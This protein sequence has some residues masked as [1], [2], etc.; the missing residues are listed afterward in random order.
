MTFVSMTPRQFRTYIRRHYPE[1]EVTE[2]RRINLGRRYTYVQV[3]LFQRGLWAVQVEHSTLGAKIQ[4]K[5]PSEGR[6]W[7][8]IR[9]EDAEAYAKA[10]V[11]AA[12]I[13]GKVGTHWTERVAA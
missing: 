4:V 13:L 12:E 2:D 9:P 6:T 11:Q 3:K 8:H 1:A 7:V 5:N 10:L